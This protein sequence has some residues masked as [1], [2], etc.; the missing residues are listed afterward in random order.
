MPVGVVN[1]LDIDWRLPSLSRARTAWPGE[2]L[3]PILRLQAADDGWSAEPTDLSL[4][5]YRSSLA[6]EGKSFSDE[7]G[8]EVH[9]A[10]DQ[11]LDDRA[12]E[13]DDS[14]TLRA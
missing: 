12:S 8:R 3:F 14:E 6:H 13:R 9:A 5:P 1:P 4:R 10:S 2:V 7:D 11:V